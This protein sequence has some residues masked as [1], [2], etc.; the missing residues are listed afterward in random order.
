MNKK[1]CQVQNVL[2]TASFTSTLASIEAQLSKQDQIPGEVFASTI[3]SE[4]YVYKVEDN[5]VELIVLVSR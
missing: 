1:S 4:A 2:T 3:V 5:L